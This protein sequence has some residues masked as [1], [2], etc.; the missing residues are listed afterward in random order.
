MSEPA[1]NTPEDPR[2]LAADVPSVVAVVKDTDKF[3]AFDAML[4]QAHFFDTLEAVRAKAGKP[5]EAFRIALKP[6]FMMA[7]LLIFLFA[8]Y[9]DVLPATGYRPLSEGIWANLRT[10]ILP[11]VT[12]AL[13]ESLALM[14]VLRSAMIATLK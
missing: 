5:K 1:P 10:F 14:R 6:N 12:L 3:A 4:E 11:S 7:I 2:D 13:I 8:I 9:F